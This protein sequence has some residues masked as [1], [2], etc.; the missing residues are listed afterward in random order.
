MFQEI[1]ENVRQKPALVHS[2][3]NYVTVNDCANILLACGASPI[4]ADDVAEVEEITS[5]CSAL[6]VNIGTLNTRTIDSMLK[7][8]KRANELVHP[9]VLDPVGAGASTL[10]TQTAMRL[11]RECRY[12][13][14]RGNMSEIKTLYDGSGTTRGVDANVA[15]AVTE[16]NIEEMAEI[17]K[18]MS[19]QFSAIVAITGEIDIVADDKRAYAIRNGNALMSKITGTGCMLSCLVAAFCASNPA[20]MLAA[21]ASAVAAMGY[22]GEVGYHKIKETNGGTSSYRMYIIDAMSNLTP[23][24]FEEGAK[25]EVI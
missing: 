15:D 9:T 12:D 8:T 1:L 16:E 6:T 19:A 18:A 22:C 5:I 2:I 24:Q 17:A 21:T 13:V 4:M 25:I 3:T 10:R 11:L 23:Q 14:I 7:A 20:Q